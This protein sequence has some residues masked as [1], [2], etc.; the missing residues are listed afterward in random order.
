MMALFNI[1]K[2]DTVYIRVPIQ[3]GKYVS[4]NV[5]L[6][7]LS[8][9]PVI[10]KEPDVNK[11]RLNLSKAPVINLDNSD[12]ADNEYSPSVEVSK[13][14]GRNVKIKKETLAKSKVST[15]RSTPFPHDTPIKEEED[16]KQFG[17]FQ[18]QASGG[19]G[20][21]TFK[22]GL[23][24]VIVLDSDE[25]EPAQQLRLREF[26]DVGEDTIVVDA[27]GSTI[28]VDATTGGSL[29]TNS[30]AIPL[31]H[32]LVSLQSSLRSKSLAVK[33]TNPSLDLTL[34]VVQHYNDVKLQKST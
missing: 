7:D 28:V 11:P 3:D 32:L 24:G 27:T 10:K 4:R 8:Y 13:R 34:Y 1:K 17:S 19:G 33:L 15:R 22:V 9:S 26:M 30:L 5:K 2:G 14:R 23:G 21:S 25:E 18:F 12:D 6:Q 29:A 31:L 16:T 20:R